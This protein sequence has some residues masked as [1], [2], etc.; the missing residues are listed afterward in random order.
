MADTAVFTDLAYST[1]V[2]RLNGEDPQFSGFPTVRYY[3]RGKRLW[4]PREAGQSQS[5]PS[6]FTFS[7]NAALVLLDYLTN[8]S[9]GV[10]VPLSQI[11]LPGFRAAAN[12][13]DEVVQTGATV[14]GRVY[15]TQTTRD[16]RRHEFN[17][18]LS[19]GVNHQRNIEQI[20]NTI[21]G[22]ILIYTAEG[23]YKLVVPDSSRTRSA[24]TV[25][26]LGTRDLTTEVS[27]TYP[28]TRD[29]LNQATVSYANASQDFAD[30]T[31]TYPNN[32]T[33]AYRTL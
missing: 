17:G 19:S 25:R 6:T 27:I 33:T 8:T 26:V 15:G 29:K 18:S 12:T 16:I 2:Y 24:Q 5:D 28:S 4:D 23:R 30:D 3:I 13:A 32:T 10:G 7:N 1:G 9:Y 31:I 22:G 21:P 14:G 11:D 20:V